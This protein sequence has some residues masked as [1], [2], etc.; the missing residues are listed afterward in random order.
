V[1]RL[2]VIIPVLVLFVFITS[3]SFAHQDFSF[4]YMSTAGMFEDVYDFFKYSPAYL[5]SMQRNTLWSQLSNLYNANDRVFAYSGT[6]YFLLGGQMDMGL[7]RGG[8]MI[9]WYS[10]SSAQYVTDYNGN[11]DY[12]FQESTE[13]DY[14]DQDSDGVYDYRRESYARIEKNNHR[15]FN[16]VYLAFG[17]GGIAGFD[18]GAAIRADWSSYQPTW[19]DWNSDVSLNELVKERQYDLLTNTELERYDYTRTGSLNYGASTWR[20]ILGARSQGLVPGLD[21]IANAGAILSLATNDYEYTFEE[22]RITNPGSSLSSEI[23]SK[24]TQKGIEPNANESGT[25]FFPGSGIGFLVN[26]R[27]DYKLSNDLVIIGEAGFSLAPRVVSD[28][29]LETQNID[30][31]TTP[32]GSLT[33]VDENTSNDNYTYEGNVTTTSANLGL[34]AQYTAKGWKLGMGVRASTT[35]NTSDITTKNTYNYQGRI[36]GSGSTSVDCTSIATSGYEKQKV[37]ITI[38]DVLEFPVG[39]VINILDNLP[40]RFGASH[41]ITITSDYN[42]E[43]YNSRTP[44]TMTTTYDNGVVTQTTADYINQSGQDNNSTVSADHSTSFYYGLTWWP[45]ENLQIDVANFYWITYL[46][47]YRLSITFHF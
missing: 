28:A 24:S 34:R 33:Q 5:P 42:K 15:Y 45:F 11:S 10:R 36:T 1:K 32:N 47:D 37:D 26:L 2:L 7:G 35:N 21:L 16:D 44:Y 12:G 27:G 43:E 40:I 23:Y 41:M 13:Y 6:G 38:T 8:G 4:T 3:A 31:N 17:M 22:T 19:N 29:K 18:L 9:D 30:R 25:Y 20:A 14:L 46:A 39:L